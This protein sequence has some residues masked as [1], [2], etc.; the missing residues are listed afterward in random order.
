[1]S[2]D[3][4]ISSLF[5]LL[6]SPVVRPG[7]FFISLIY[8]GRRRRRLISATVPPLTACS[9]TTA[10]VGRSRVTLR[11]VGEARS[12]NQVPSLATSIIDRS[13]LIGKV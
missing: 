4:D 6:A 12:E 11:S 1:M 8:T 3:T 2:L 13:R 7:E 9:P 5:S 10:A